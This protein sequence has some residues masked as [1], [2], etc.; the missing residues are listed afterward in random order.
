MTEPPLCIKTAG[1]MEMKSSTRKIR[2]SRLLESTKPRTKKLTKRPN[3]HQRGVAADNEEQD[4]YVGHQT[5][6]K[7]TDRANLEWGCQGIS[8]RSQ[9]R[10]RRQR[11]PCAFGC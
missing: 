4:S 3:E 10:V 9:G 5:G 11:A 7:N 6:T 2:T 8:P 1:P